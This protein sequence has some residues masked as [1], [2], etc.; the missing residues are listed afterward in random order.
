MR[1][2]AVRYFS[3]MHLFRSSPLFRVT[4]LALIA[5]VLTG[6]GSGCGKGSSLPPFEVD[7]YLDNPGNLTG[8]RY[9][10]VGDI[11]AHL[12]FEEGVG[13]LVSV[14]A[15]DDAPRLPVFIHDDLRTNVHVGQR[16][17][18]EVLVREGGLIYVEQME[19]Y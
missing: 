18:F 17:T 13:R 9:S 6:F 8:N 12:E 7:S 4:R 19:K 16:Y 2:L 15:G 5:L 14:R 10:L 1:R 3:L 11:D